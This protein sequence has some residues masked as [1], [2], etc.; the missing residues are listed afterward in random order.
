MVEASLRLLVADE[1]LV[2]SE[3]NDFTEVWSYVY[4]MAESATF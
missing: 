4:E 1:T 3:G 2:E